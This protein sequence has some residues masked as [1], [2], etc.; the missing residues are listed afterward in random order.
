MSTSTSTF[1]NDVPVSFYAE[2]DPNHT[3]S[4]TNEGNNRYPASGTITLNFRKRDTLKTVGWRLRYHPS[5]YGGEQYASGWAVNGGAADWW[6]QLLPIR[7]NGINY[8]LKSGYL[9]WTTSLGSGDGQHSLISYLN[10]EWMKEN[11]FCVHLR[12]RDIDWRQS[13]LRLGAERRLFRRPCRHAHLSA[14]G[15]P[16]RGGHRHRPSRHQ[17]R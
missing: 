6:E 16:G 9:N 7:N 13:P 15:R 1:R 3:I 2:V 11:L 17:H 5:G 14:R 4:E 8:V 10:L 12:H